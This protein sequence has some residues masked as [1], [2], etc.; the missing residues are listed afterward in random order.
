[1]PGA[2]WCDE[3]DIHECRDDGTGST[4]LTTCPEDRPC[5]N[6]ECR[7]VCT[8]GAL[9]CED[10]VLLRCDAAGSAWDEYMVCAAGSYCDSD[11]GGCLVQSCVPGARSCADGVA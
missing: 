6:G 7:P 4:V 8:P 1:M 2:R 10:D 3:N 5:E 11:E 9:L